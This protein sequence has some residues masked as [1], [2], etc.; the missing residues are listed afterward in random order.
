MI[1]HILD[2]PIESIL[3]SRLRNL[4]IST[5]L[6][7]G[8]PLLLNGLSTLDFLS[9]INCKIPLAISFLK[10]ISLHFSPQ[11]NFNMRDLRVLHRNILH[12]AILST[13]FA[14]FMILSF[15]C[16]VVLRL[17]LLD[18]WDLYLG[19]TILTCM[20]ACDYEKLLSFK[21]YFWVPTFI[22]SWRI[23]RSGHFSFQTSPQQLYLR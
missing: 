4:V 12:V 3:T 13:S 15:I 21:D 22:F 7:G 20:K 16:S 6:A 14:N 2:L 1:D 11:K 18:I 10:S 19:M 8:A 9:Q 17:A 23:L 5:T